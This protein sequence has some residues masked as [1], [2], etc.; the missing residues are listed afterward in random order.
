MI[1][2]TIFSLNIYTINCVQF[3]YLL[4][5]YFWNN[6]YKILNV[7]FRSLETISKIAKRITELAFTF[8][9]VLHFWIRKC[10]RR[11]GMKTTWLPFTHL[12]IGPHT[13]TSISLQL[14]FCGTP[15]IRNRWVIHQFKCKRNI[16]HLNH[17]NKSHKYG[18]SKKY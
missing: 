9:K 2:H 6:A 5:L 7:D 12:L 16:F 10:D 11:T 18:V 4:F 14:T 13:Y 3:D 8:G 1:F 15:W 17:K